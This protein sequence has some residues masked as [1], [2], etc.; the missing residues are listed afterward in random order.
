ML[1]TIPFQKITNK[2][3]FSN[4]YKL[5]PAEHQMPLIFSGNANRIPFPIDQTHENNNQVVFIQ[6]I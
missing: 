4:D 5:F 1:R 2:K 3:L 6:K